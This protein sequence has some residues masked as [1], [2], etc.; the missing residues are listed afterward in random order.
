M[1]HLT[2]ANDLIFCSHTQ[3]K[4]EKENCPDDSKGYPVQPWLYESYILL[5][6][7]RLSVSTDKQELVLA[8]RG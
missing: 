8:H 4:I 2:I 5:T 7:S 3:K 6:T 1:D